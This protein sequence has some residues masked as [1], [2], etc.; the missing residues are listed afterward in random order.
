MKSSVAQE[1]IKQVKELPDDAL[2]QVLDYIETLNPSD[3][4]EVTGSQMLR[5]A[6][7]I[8]SRDLRRMKQAIEAE[9]ERV[10]PS[11]W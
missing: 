4:H 9:C 3:K 7:T 10:N 6:G 11:E 5:F 1:I 2:R 8:P